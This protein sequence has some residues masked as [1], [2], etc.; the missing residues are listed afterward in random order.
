LTFDSTDGSFASINPIDFS[1]R[2]AWPDKFLPMYGTIDTL[3]AQVATTATGAPVTFQVVFSVYD[4]KGGFLLGTIET[5]PATVPEL[6]TMEVTAP[7]DTAVWGSPKYYWF[8][9]FYLVRV[10]AQ[11][12]YDSN[13][14][15]IMDTLGNR[16]KQF[17]ILVLA[18]K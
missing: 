5:E 1:H 16:V 9:G 7:F 6:T 15:G 8:I 11:I 14:D 2:G 17:Y 10:R 18:F 12:I 13:G 3:H 4:A